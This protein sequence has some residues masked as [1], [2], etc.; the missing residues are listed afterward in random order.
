MTRNL[1]RFFSIREG[2]GSTWEFLGVTGAIADNCPYLGLHATEEYNLLS[3]CDTIPVEQLG[4]S[5]SRCRHWS[6]QCLVNELMT[7]ALDEG[8]NPLSRITVGGLEDLG[9]V[10]D[11]SNVG[12]YT[13]DNIDPSCLCNNR[14]ERQLLRQPDSNQKSLFSGRHGDVVLLNDLIEGPSKKQNQEGRQLSESLRQYA[15]NYG[16]QILDESA[17][18]RSWASAVLD[19]Q[20]GDGTERTSTGS[21]PNNKRVR[22]AGHYYISIM[23]REG[24]DYFGVLVVREGN[25]E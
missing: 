2:I 19:I 10:V 7:T 16:L 20:Q 6:E 5:G 21:D 17:A 23:M 9:Y 4:T 22:Y 11:Y 12:A 3:G 18:R 15:I 8:S 1:F 24:N 25:D 14:K 13:R